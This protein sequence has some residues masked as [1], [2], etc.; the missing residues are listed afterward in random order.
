MASL[1]YP[2][3]VDLHG[4]EKVRLPGSNFALKHLTNALPTWLRL[5]EPPKDPANPD[6]TLPLELLVIL[7]PPRRP[8]PDDS[9]DPDISCLNFLGAMG[10]PEDIL[11]TARHHKQS[12][13]KFEH[14]RLVCLIQDFVEYLMDNLTEITGEANAAVALTAFKACLASPLF[15]DLRFIIRAGLFGTALNCLSRAAVAMLPTYRSKAADLDLGLLP[16]WDNNDPKLVGRWHTL[17]RKAVQLAMEAAFTTEDEGYQQPL[18]YF[19]QGPVLESAKLPVAVGHLGPL[20]H[21]FTTPAKEDTEELHLKVADKATWWSSQDLASGAYNK[22]GPDGEYACQVFRVGAD[23]KLVAVRDERHVTTNITSSKAAKTGECSRSTA[24]APARWQAPLPADRELRDEELRARAA[25]RAGMQLPGSRAAAVQDAR[26]SLESDATAP[27]PV[28]AGAGRGQGRGPAVV[29]GAARGAGRAAARG[30]ASRG[31][32]RQ[33]RGGAAGPGARGGRAQA[34]RGGRGRGPVGPMWYGDPR[35]ALPQM[36]PHAFYGPPGYVS[37]GYG[38]PQP[39]AAP[40][41]GYEEYEAE[42]GELAEDAE[43]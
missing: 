22:P 25:A 38:M 30:N 1:R 4:L 28:E 19:G 16:A 31:A 23:D 3:R 6:N 37:D 42:V 29:R 32:G 27:P 24:A 17:Q 43:A 10:L 15:K 35:A 36:Q 41:D 5:A 20:L 39:W 34:G 11:P 2:A 33:P 7:L 18:L 14:V 13:T 40:W 21:Y 26:M 9:A 12:K 8:T